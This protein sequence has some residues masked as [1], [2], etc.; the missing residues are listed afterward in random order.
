[1]LTCCRV[2][3]DI[4]SRRLREEAKGDFGSALK[5]LSLETK[6]GSDVIIYRMETN[7]IETAE[8]KLIF[9]DI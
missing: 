7:T 9:F 1:L 2:P 5:V 8:I 6:R 3:R 4:L